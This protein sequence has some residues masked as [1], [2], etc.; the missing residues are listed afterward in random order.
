MSRKRHESEELL[1]G[2]RREPGIANTSTHEGDLIQQLLCVLPVA[3]GGS[4]D[5]AMDVCPGVPWLL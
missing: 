5:Y 2:Y 1:L 3:Y 4:H